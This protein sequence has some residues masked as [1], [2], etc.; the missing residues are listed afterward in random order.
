MT[1]LSLDQQFALRR[2]LRE[3]NDGERE[4]FEVVAGATA[5]ALAEGR[6]VTL[7]SNTGVVV[8]AC[9][10]LGRCLGA[11][12]ETIERLDGMTDI[13]LRPRRRRLAT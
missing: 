9:K 5:A 10:Q 8:D 11:A 1:V 4:W 12:I 13:I 2:E 7:S 6:P 3:L